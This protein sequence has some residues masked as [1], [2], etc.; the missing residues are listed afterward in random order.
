MKCNS[1]SVFF[2]VLAESGH[3]G[4]KSAIISQGFDTVSVAMC[5]AT[6][7]LDHV[8]PSES[9]QIAVHR[10][11]PARGLPARKFVDFG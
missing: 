9:L 3:K 1:M 6:G 10:S 5:W 8:L 11:V 4:H 7:L 2:S